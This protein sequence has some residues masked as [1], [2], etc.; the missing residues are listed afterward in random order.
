MDDMAYIR[1]LRSEPVPS[2][3]PFPRAEFEARVARLQSEMDARGLD[4]LLICDPGNMFY[5]SGYYTFETSLHA[6]IL[7]PRT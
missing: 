2:E 6:C 3:L 1:A 5:V 4:A 7:L